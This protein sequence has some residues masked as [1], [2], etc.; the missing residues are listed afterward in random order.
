MQN[1]S[2]FDK[3]SVH[4]ERRPWGLSNCAKVVYAEKR[5][6]KKQPNLAQ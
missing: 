5:K 6:Y 2:F 3:G 4:L 1:Q